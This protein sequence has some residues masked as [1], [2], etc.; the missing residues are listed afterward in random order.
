M[1]RYGKMKNLMRRMLEP[2]G[3]RLYFYKNMGMLF[4]CAVM[5]R[6]YD[7]EYCTLEADVS[8]FEETADLIWQ[9]LN[10]ND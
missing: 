2:R 7:E 9:K 3:V 8:L 4:V 6:K 10:S 1:A 5:D